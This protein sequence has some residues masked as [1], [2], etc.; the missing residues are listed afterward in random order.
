MPI[1]TYTHKH[2]LHTILSH[3]TAR[4]RALTREEV[5]AIFETNKKETHALVFGLTWFRNRNTGAHSNNC[6]IYVRLA[7]LENALKHN[8]TLYE[9]QYTIT[10][11]EWRNDYKSSQQ[12][13]STLDNKYQ[14]NISSFNSQP[15]TI[16]SQPA[17]HDN[18]R[19][20]PHYDHLYI[21]QNQPYQTTGAPGETRNSSGV[22]HVSQQSQSSPSSYNINNN[23]INQYGS[24]G[25]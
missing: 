6:S 14:D 20:N 21:P 4:P 12:N 9:R 24:Q 25:K 23:N 13:Q 3:T 7:H 1:H 5:K 11:R 15:Q 8:N 17:Q 2:P 18:R 16:N 22:V 19:G 10:A